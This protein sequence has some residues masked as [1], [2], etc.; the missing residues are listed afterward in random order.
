M[1]K[2]LVFI[3]S[4]T[5]VALTA[6]NYPVEQQSDV[7]ESESSAQK[8]VK[9]LLKSEVK[10]AAPKMRLAEPEM[11]S[12]VAAGIMLQPSVSAGRHIKAMALPSHVNTENYAHIDENGLQLVAQQPVSTFSIDV[13]TG[14]YTNTRRMISDGV[15]PP[16][17]AVRVEEFINY[18]S[19]NETKLELADQPFSMTSEAGPT[20]WNEN[21]RLIRL[22]LNSKAIDSK[23]IKPSNLVF[24]IDVSGSMRAPDKL[25][26]LRK[27]LKLLSRQMGGDDRIA[28]VMYAGNS[29]VALDT[30]AGNAVLKIEQALDELKA[31]GSTNGEAGIKLAYKLARQSFIENGNNRVILATDGDFNVGVVNHEALLDLVER[32]RRDGIALSTLGFGSGNYNDHLMEQLADHGNGN[33]AYIDNLFEARKVLVDELGATLQTVASDVKIQVEFNPQ[34]VSEYRLIGYENRKLAREDFNNDKVDAGDIGAGHSVTALYEITPAGAYSQVDPLRYQAG[35]TE[36]KKAGNSRSNELAFVKIRFKQPSAEHSKLLT[37]AVM[38]QD[39]RQRLAHTSDDFRFAA[40]VAAYGQQLRGGKYLHDFSW[41]QIH[42]LASESRG[43]DPHGLRSNFLQMIGMTQTLD[44][45]H[46]PQLAHD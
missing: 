17:D 33:H 31:G 15:L 8:A 37:F 39:V 41:E 12:D 20:P 2:S 28:I 6:C 32:N 46:Q 25:D 27:S 3:T 19:Y 5:L 22:T 24:L 43:K 38:K 4:T 16:Q 13:D 45:L 7:V 35:E 9:Q 1:N 21:T 34:Q 40:A 11:A 23:Q 26:L 30:V 36:R 42:A 10:T 29:G 44:A 14:S 18:F